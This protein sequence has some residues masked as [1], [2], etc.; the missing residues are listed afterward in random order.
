MSGEVWRC[1]WPPDVTVS[2]TDVHI[3]RLMEGSRP[4]P[5]TTAALGSS[6][7]TA[8]EQ[9]LITAGRRSVE[10]PPKLLPHRPTRSQ[11]HRD[12]QP[13]C[14]DPVPNASTHILTVRSH[15]QRMAKKMGEPTRSQFQSSWAEHSTSA[16]TATTA[17]STTA[18]A[19]PPHNALKPSGPSDSTSPTPQGATPP[20]APAGP[21]GG[22][23]TMALPSDQA[24]QS[25]RDYLSTKISRDELRDI[26]LVFHSLDTGPLV[27]SPTPPLPDLRC[28][29]IARRSIEKIHHHHRHR[30]QQRVKEGTTRDERRADC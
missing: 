7:I 11:F 13:G 30:N 26:P 9:G 21:G 1:Q 17:A 27:K 6:Y 2:V 5:P 15:C 28:P 12:T 16:A 23:V 3:S 19:K 8:S 4:E 20:L 24:M 14:T 10:R 25:T 22:R 29:R 18:D